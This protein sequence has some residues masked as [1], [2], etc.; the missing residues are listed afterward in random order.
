MLKYII[1]ILI[2]SFLIFFHE[3]GHFIAAKLCGVRVLKFAIGMGPKI[4]GKTIGETEYSIRVFPFGG[5]CAM[6][7]E[8]TDAVSKHELGEQ[9]EVS[10]DR[11]LKKR[12]YWQRFIIL[13]AGPFM[14]VFL[15]FI[16]AV[17]VTC[18]L[19]LVPSNVVK[20]FHTVSETDKSISASSCDSGLM[21]GDEIISINGMRIFCPSDMS[22]QLYS[23]ENETFE[24]VVERSGEEVTLRNVVFYDKSAGSAIDFYVEGLEKTPLN[25]AGYSLRNTI[26]TAR[27]IWISLG[28][29]ISGKYGFEEM[30][31]PVGVVSEI[32]KTA[33]SGKTAGESAR[34]LMSLTMFITVNLGI[35]NLLPI[36]GLD[37]GQLLFLIIEAIRRKPIKP[38]H[39]GMINLIGLGLVLLLIVAVT[40][41]DII[42]LIG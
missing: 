36:P 7:G 13:F 37:G 42:K 15:G 11:S 28:D 10:S 22:Y 17:I 20:D 25:V 2:F 29:L 24:V 23:H 27:L 35:M 38:E 3:L 40:F 4:I 5:F 32:G 8:D 30:S 19:R 34:S 33:V 41:G 14:N 31:G 26:S 16:L 9:A 6:E 39:E 1:G 12:P 21:A 18:T